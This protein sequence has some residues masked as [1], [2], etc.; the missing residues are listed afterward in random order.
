M[1]SISISSL[2]Q[3]KFRASTLFIVVLITLIL[4]ACSKDA[5][6][7]VSVPDPCSVNPPTFSGTVNAAIQSSCTDSGCHGAN[8]QNGPG[9]LV[10]YTQIANARS[11]IR[12][13][14][15][16]GS[17]PLG[18]TLSASTKAAILCWIDNGAPEN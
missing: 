3:L 2:N 6:T 8:S 12:S 10:T 7:P 11:S 14:V 4:S 9:A 18:R 15:A 16:S 17:M 13:A 1:R 5:D